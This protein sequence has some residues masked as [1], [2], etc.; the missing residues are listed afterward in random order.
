MK[1]VLFWREGK[2]R[3]EQM[4]NFWSLPSFASKIIYEWC[5]RCIYTIKQ[6]KEFI[7]HCYLAIYKM[8]S[9][10]H[11]LNVIHN[12]AQQRSYASQEPPHCNEISMKVMTFI[13]SLISSHCHF[14]TKKNPVSVIS[15]SY[16]KIA[17]LKFLNLVCPVSSNL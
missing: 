8:N 11:F 1:P 6:C 14:L 3:K 2:R 12:E 9:S 4:N 13:F 7:D 5:H 15:N 10:H 16:T 17:L